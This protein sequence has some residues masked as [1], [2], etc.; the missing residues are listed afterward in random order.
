M[1]KRVTLNFQRD[2][3]SITLRITDEGRGFAWQDYLEMNPDRAC[4]PNGRGIALARMLSFNSIFYEG[5]GNVAVATLANP[6][7]R[8]SA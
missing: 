7:D 5:C 8:L 2:G 3:Q 1:D 4:D 6:S